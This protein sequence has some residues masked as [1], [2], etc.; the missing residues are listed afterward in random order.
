MMF[1]GQMRVKTEI[2]TVL[3][4]LHKFFNTLKAKE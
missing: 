4:I 2:R 1:R 3:E